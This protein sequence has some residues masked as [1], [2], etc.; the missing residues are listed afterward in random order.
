MPLTES[1]TRLAYGSFLRP[2]GATTAARHMLHQAVHTA[3]NCRA[4]RLER[5]AT[6]ELHAVGGRR[7]TGH[8]DTETLTPVQNRIATLVANGLT[9]GEIGRQLLISHRTVEHLYRSK[10]RRGV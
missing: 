9:N 5:L 7:R 4:A 8:P 1:E 10:I 2:T 3:A 6:E